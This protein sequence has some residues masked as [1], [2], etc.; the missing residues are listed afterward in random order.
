MRKRKAEGVEKVRK[1]KSEGVE[2]VRKGKAEG[3]RSEE[4]KGR[5]GR[6]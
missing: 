6:R 3:G 2:K 4:G 5:G 1:G